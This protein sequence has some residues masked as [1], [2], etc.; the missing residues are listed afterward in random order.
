MATAIRIS[1]LDEDLLPTAN[2]DFERA[3]AARS[4]VFPII[5]AEVRRDKDGIGYATIKSSLESIYRNGIVGIRVKGK[6]TLD[7]LN[8]IRSH[9][10]RGDLVRIFP[11]YYGDA[12]VFYDGFLDI[13]NLLRYFALG[14]EDAAGEILNLRFWELDLNNQAV[15]VDD[16]LYG[17]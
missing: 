2:Y 13:P 16:E 12:S 3:E 7:D 10:L 6:S 9:L 5:Q 1:T 8:T 17:D 15:V 11:K 14:G 4:R